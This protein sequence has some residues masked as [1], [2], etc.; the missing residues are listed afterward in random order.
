VPLVNVQNTFIENSVPFFCEPFNRPEFVVVA[1]PP[2]SKAQLPSQIVRDTELA[3]RSLPTTTWSSLPRVRPSAT[4]ACAHRFQMTQQLKRHNQICQS[5]HR[6]PL[7]NTDSFATCVW[8]LPNIAVHSSPAHHHV[9]SHESLSMKDISDDALINAAGQRHI[10]VACQ[11]MLHRVCRSHCHAGQSNTYKSFYRKKSDQKHN[12]HVRRNGTT[13]VRSNDAPTYEMSDRHQCRQ[14]CSLC[15]F[16][17]TAEPSR[18]TST[19][20]VY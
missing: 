5:K 14:C 18:G 8:T 15:G 17:P 16:C 19:R 10:T 2:F 3:D 1:L 9:I 7:M 12:I 20:R 6:H 13:T 4:C 11:R